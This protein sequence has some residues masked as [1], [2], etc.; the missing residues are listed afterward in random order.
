MS[1]E[2]RGWGRAKRASASARPSAWERL[3]QV[4]DLAAKIL[5]GI[6]AGVVSIVGYHYQQSSTTAQILSQREQSDSTIRAE[7]FKALSDK[8]FSKKEPNLLP[9]DEKAIFAEVL[10]LNFH[11][12]IDLKPLL[13]DL[14]SRLK[15][16]GP[17][18]ANRRHELQSVARRIRARQV[19]VLTDVDSASPA[20]SRFIK[21]VAAGVSSGEKSDNP[22][23]DATPSGESKEQA[24][25][26][27]VINSAFGKVAFVRFQSGTGSGD[28]RCDVERETEQVASAK[29]NRC[30]LEPV[31]LSVP[32]IAGKPART[33]SI[34]VRKVDFENERFVVY[35]K[36]HPL[37]QTKPSDQKT[38][39]V[40][41]GTGPDI[42]PTQ[43]RPSKNGGSNPGVSNGQA[44]DFE[45]TWFDL[46]LT[47][48]TQLETGQRY[49]LFIDQVCRPLSNST[50]K[51]D[52]ALRIGV[53]W[54]PQ[55]YFP[56]HERPTNYEK[57]KQQ[58]DIGYRPWYASILRQ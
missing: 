20:K 39:P 28:G 36:L 11:E 27:D 40:P 58:L 57:V 42:C 55:Y 45:L 14:D 25:R 49:A 33:I 10:A 51:R 2:R 54:F 47:D 30:I 24:A 16:Q 34:E 13:L 23:G 12:H 44:I 6:A 7:M 26:V 35:T 32:A 9:P 50:D 17:G 43:L 4:T 29:P 15:D 19:Q 8:L 48:N 46:P 1:E 22:A 53:L 56:A 37:D 5:L 18:V 52:G 41:E 31:F 38:N 21:Q 3:N